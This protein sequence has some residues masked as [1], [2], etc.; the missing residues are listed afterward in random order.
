MLVAGGASSNASRWASP[1]SSQREM[2]VTYSRVCTTSARLAPSCSRAALTFSSAC[3]VCLATS[4]S[5][6]IL[7]SEIDVHPL[8]KMKSPAATARL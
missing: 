1:T 4:P 3:S 8:T 2:S 5:W 7:P 6:T